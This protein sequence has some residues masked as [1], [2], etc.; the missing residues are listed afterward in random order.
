MILLRVRTLKQL[1]STFRHRFL[2]IG[3]KEAPWGMPHVR[4]AQGQAQQIQERLLSVI[5]ARFGTIMTSSNGSMIGV[6]HH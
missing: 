5:A 6:V 4:V 2:V 1:N 3:D